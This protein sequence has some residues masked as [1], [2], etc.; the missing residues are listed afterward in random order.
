M[1]KIKGNGRDNNL[2]GTSSSDTISAFGGDDFLFGGSG[3]DTLNGGGGDDELSGGKGNDKLAGGAG[4]DILVGGAGSDELNGGADNDVLS[5]GAGNDILIGGAGTDIM[6]GGAGD[7]IFRFLPGVQTPAGT[8][9][10]D[11]ITDFNQLA[12]VGGD[13]L[14]V[15][16][17][18]TI[19][20]SFQIVDS[21][22]SSWFIQYTRN[23]AA[24]AGFVVLAGLAEA[25]DIEFV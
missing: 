4:I 2:F 22:V 12:G 19:D 9:N 10:A 15:P 1:G 7:D 18:S 14:Q 24:D 5:G 3:N 20:Y 16:A 6:V 25:P 21:G 23:A 11:I 17:G 8:Q 13:V